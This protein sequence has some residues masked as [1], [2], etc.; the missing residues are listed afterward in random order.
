MLVTIT[1]TITVTVIITVTT[2]I[3][4]IITMGAALPQTPLLALIRHE[5]NVL[6]FVVTVVAVLVA[7]IV[8]GSNSSNSDNATVMA[9]LC[10]Y[11]NSSSRSSTHPSASSVCRWCV[12]PS[13]CAST[14]HAP[15]LLGKSRQVFYAPVNAQ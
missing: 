15:A 3:I 14:M 2:A 7:V 11:G 8:T 5:S 9:A 10:G 4:A 6:G 13:L 12:E 1:V